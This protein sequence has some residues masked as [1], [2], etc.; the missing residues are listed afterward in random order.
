MKHSPSSLFIPRAS[1]SAS[2]P[3]ST[4]GWSYDSILINSYNKLRYSNLRLLLQKL[5][6]CCNLFL[7]QCNV[8]RR[9]PGR[10]DLRN[11]P[12][13]K[14]LTGGV[15]S[16]LLRSEPPSTRFPLLPSV[17]RM[18]PSILWINSILTRNRPLSTSQLEADLELVETPPSRQL[19]NLKPAL[20]MNHLRQFCCHSSKP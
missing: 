5:F 1:A 7:R 15:L 13:I 6:R 9:E 10:K 18:L 16:R 8:P 2:S 17:I 14:T 19:Q 4:L 20:P 11:T 3:I 12:S